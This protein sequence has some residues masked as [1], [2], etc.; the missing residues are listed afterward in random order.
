[1]T[2]HAS[3]C[4]HGV[5]PL[6]YVSNALSPG[7][8]FYCLQSLQPLL[9]IRGKFRLHLGHMFVSLPICRRVCLVTLLPLH[10]SVRPSASLGQ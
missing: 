6:Q 8:V 7:I 2:P 4:D 10:V 1:M 3:M 5:F 9:P